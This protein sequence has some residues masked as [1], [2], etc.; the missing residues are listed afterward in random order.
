LSN[1]SRNYEATYI[2]KRSKA[3]AEKDNEVDEVDAPA[4]NSGVERPVI[5]GDKVRR[6]VAKVLSLLKQRMSDYEMAWD[7]SANHVFKTALHGIE[8]PGR[9]DMSGELWLPAHN[10]HSAF[11]MARMHTPKRP[12][13][14]EGEQGE[15]E[16]VEGVEQVALDLPIVSRPLLD[17]LLDRHEQIRNTIGEHKIWAPIHT[18]TPAAVDLSI[19]I[20]VA[21]W[22]LHST[23]RA[24]VLDTVLMCLW[25]EKCTCCFRR[26]RPR[27]RRRGDDADDDDDDDSDHDDDADDDEDDDDGAMDDMDDDAKSMLREL[28]RADKAASA[29]TSTDL[30]GADGP[31]NDEDRMGLAY[32][33]PDSTERDAKTATKILRS[34]QAAR[35]KADIITALNESKDDADNSTQSHGSSIAE[36]AAST[37]QDS[38]EGPPQS[39]EHPVAYEEEIV[40]DNIMH[41][42]YADMWEGID[43][44]DDDN[45]N[46]ETDNI[47]DERHKDSTSAVLLGAW[48]EGVK[49]ALIDFDFV[50]K[51]PD[52]PSAGKT[53]LVKY[54]HRGFSDEE[55]VWSTRWVEWDIVNLP[56]L[57]G[58][59]TT[60][61]SGY[62][63]YVPT[64]VD[65]CNVK[66]LSADY[67]AGHLQLM[68]P[69][70]GVHMFR[71][72][73]SD[74]NRMP[75]QILEVRER[76]EEA[77]Q[78]AEVD[79][80]KV[81]E[82]WCYVCSTSW[83]SGACLAKRC[84]VCRLPFHDDCFESL[85]RHVG[86][87]KAQECLNQ[88][89]GDQYLELV[90]SSFLMFDKP[91][92]WIDVS[93]TCPFCLQ[94]VIADITDL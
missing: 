4:G 64:G 20:V 15:S 55:R 40:V 57:K 46:R 90:L 6:C 14:P 7:I 88:S 91:P 67:A 44:E 3:P 49:A 74:R 86:V 19:S 53:G 54:A 70:T 69:D 12:K 60:V 51:L 25:S 18:H 8:H 5:I 24:S 11:W 83:G 79:D 48:T 93:L 21:S 28:D 94:V 30:D 77:L 31:S 75:R 73:G 42:T 78:H 76:I 41:R 59:F 81:A 56:V 43:G 68:V 10:F 82:C 9:A 66:D 36:V 26:R 2:T 38:L 23:N 63:A 27:R 32:A 89:L 34:K 50:Q 85:L 62:L 72:S 52:M 29:P 65:R 35:P 61:K 71:A 16:E 22:D 80:D 39:T 37:G 45:D 33:P 92:V 13:L 58:R 47:D 17:I 1:E 84:Q 87:P